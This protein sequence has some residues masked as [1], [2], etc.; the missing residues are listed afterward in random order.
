MT[1]VRAALRVTRRVISWGLLAACL[2]T[3]VGAIWWVGHGKQDVHADIAGYRPYV[4]ATG[5]MAP[6]YEVHSFVVTHET[7]FD[8][9]E[10]GDVI[11]F[12][13]A[14]LGGQAALHRVIHV[15]DDKAGEPV[16]FIVKGDNN[17]HPDGAPVTRAN[18]LGRTVFHTNATAAVW[19]AAQGPHGLIPVIAV[20]LVLIAL[21]WVGSHF[22]MAGRRTFL[23]R[24]AVATAI[25]FCLLASATASYA[26]YLNRKQDYVTSQLGKAA[27]SFEKQS[28]GQTMTIATTTVEGTIDI[29]TIDVHYPVI[30]YV[31]ASS[32]NLAI[33]HYAGPGLN[34]PGNVVLAG[35]KA[36]GNLYFTRIPRLQ[37][38][39]RIRITDSNHDT[40]AYAVTGHRRVSPDN[41][42]VL[43]QPTDGTRH[44][45][46]ISC[47]YDLLDRYIVDAVA[48]ADLA[49][50][51]AQPTRPTPPTQ[52]MDAAILGADDTIWPE[53]SIPAVLALGALAGAGAVAWIASGV[54]RRHVAG[55]QR[56]HPAGAHLGPSVRYV[57]PPT[58]VRTR[59]R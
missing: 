43:D 12:S 18:Y 38:G 3:L 58:A 55:A 28:A 5:S 30:E 32:L 8:Q 29:P 42:S 53:Y 39:D 10:R 26:M 4:V 59:G 13:A 44:L 11:A 17:P 9:I 48:V 24:A 2:A 47:T 23:G 51:P 41:T 37:Q 6:G 7:P 57:E 22:L 16:S 19:N 21:I 33:T 1:G 14:G 40:V 20:P 34:Q 36:W 15:N 25:A 56:R 49:T 52:P 27:T 50:P 35:H 45:T 46:L 31:A 54:R